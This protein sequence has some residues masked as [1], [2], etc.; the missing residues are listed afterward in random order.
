VVLWRADPLSKESY[1]LSVSFIVFRLI[2]KCEKAR[3]PNPS[4]EEEE[5]EKVWV[6]L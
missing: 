2:L 6:K 1:H 5:E 4:N 3:G